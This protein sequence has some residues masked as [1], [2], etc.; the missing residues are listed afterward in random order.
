MSTN[1]LITFIH[2]SS[3]S[4]DSVETSSRPWEQVVLHSSPWVRIP[5]D[6]VARAAEEAY[7]YDGSD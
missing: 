2:D 4:S 7:V 6:L 1:L 3:R 5:E